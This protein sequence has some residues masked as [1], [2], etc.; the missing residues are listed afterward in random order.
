[1]PNWNETEYVRRAGEVA[2]QFATIKTPLNDLCEKVARE[3]AMNPDEI[4]T[5][6][7]LSNVAAFQELFKQKEGDKMVEFDVGNPES[8]ISRIQSSVT[9]PVQPANIHNDKLASEIP[10]QMKE[11]RLGRK[12]D[13]RV[14]VAHEDVVE[15]APRADFVV[16]AMRKL[17]S[18]FDVERRMQ[19]NKWEYAVNK[20]AREYRK[21][22]T[23]QTVP[24]AKLATDAFSE[25]GEEIRPEL[26]AL[27]SEARLNIALPEREKVAQLQDRHVSDD[28]K[29]L[30]LLKEAFEAREIYV[31][32][33]NGEK[34]IQENM[35][36]L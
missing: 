3:E 12:F 35:P 19:G 25:Y 10:D 16:I 1:M 23:Y 36:R 4:R 24:F 30:K 34:W 32:I 8:V 6:V 31:K 2:K 14:K 9:D 5:L 17:A 11:I 20:L 22:S 26:E 21:L 7:R 33:Q 13:D 27:L 28:Y 18:E 29:Q 15:R